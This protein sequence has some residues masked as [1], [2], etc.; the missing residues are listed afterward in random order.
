MAMFVKQ[1]LT[2]I[3]TPNTFEETIE[4]YPRWG[5][6]STKKVVSSFVFASSKISPPRL[7]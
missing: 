5:Y 6:F 1:K 7:I 2:T 3:A 4:I